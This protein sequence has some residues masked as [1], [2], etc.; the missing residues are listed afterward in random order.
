MIW[1]VKNLFKFFHESDGGKS[2]SIKVM[3]VVAFFPPS[4]HSDGDD[5]SSSIKSDRGGGGNRLIYVH[6]DELKF[7]V[8]LKK[9]SFYDLKVVN[10][11]TEH[12]IGFKV[13]KITAPNMYCVR[14]KTGVIQARDSCVIRFT[15]RSH[16]KYPPN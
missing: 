6:P 5:I 1:K 16:R 12:H 7:L 2:S 4:I 15:H 8:E 3:S 13:I 10:N 14:P 11:N 9:Q